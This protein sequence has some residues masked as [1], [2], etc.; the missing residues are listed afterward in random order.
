DRSF[1][2]AIIDRRRSSPEASPSSGTP[3]MTTQPTE[4]TAP[5]QGNPFADVGGLTDGS[6]Q[7][8]TQDVLLRNGIDAAVEFDVKSDYYSIR[9]EG[10]TTRTQK[11]ELYAVQRVKTTDGVGFRF[12]LHQERT[13]RLLD[14]GDDASA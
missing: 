9:I 12:L 5:Q 11:N 3:A 6:V 10:A 1:A 14:T 8:L 4:T 2:Q 7:G 13:D